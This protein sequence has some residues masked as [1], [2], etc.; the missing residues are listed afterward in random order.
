MPE[1]KSVKSNEASFIKIFEDILSGTLKEFLYFLVKQLK[2][3]KKLY[4]A[5]RYKVYDSYKYILPDAEHAKDNRWNSVS[6]FIL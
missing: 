5:S 3:F 1:R 4:R 2:D 6:L